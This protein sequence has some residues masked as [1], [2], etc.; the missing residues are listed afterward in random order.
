VLDE[1]LQ[2]RRV[3][4]CVGS[5]GVGKTTVSAA[6]GL[7]AAQLG[8]KTLVLTIDPARRLANSLGLT[9]LGNVETRIGVDQ[10]AKAGIEPKAELWA[11]TLDLR[12]TWD[13]LVTRHAPTPEKRAM[14]LNNRIYRQLSTKLAG[15]LEYMATEK[16]YELDR[17]GGY[18]LVVLDTPPT[19]HALDFI[20]APHR[21]LDV[22]ENDAARLL[23]N[24]ALA[25]GRVGLTIMHLGSSFILRSLAR[26]TGAGLLQDLSDF[27][28][29]FQ[30]MY[31][32]FK[33]R[34]AATRELLSSNRAGFILVSGP[35]PQTI[36]E[37]LFFASELARNNI[38]VAAS[39]VNRVQA[40]PAIAGDAQDAVALAVAL[41]RARVPNEGHPHLSERLAV[42][43]AELSNLARRDAA[44]IRRLREATAGRFALWQ[45]PKLERDVHDLGGL[46]QVTQAFAPVPKAGG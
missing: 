23:L 45:V 24:P 40:D 8:R 36:D 28:V 39:V 9:T 29:A 3:I 26:F 17:A 2:S 42:T 34:A 35:Q 37:A 22:F 15:S 14:I 5:G 7:R 16:V 1:L 27:L 12:R 33:E 20:D 6:L 10:F 41:A 31:D 18:D 13:D 4:V 32:G 11:M 38:A 44:Q 21:L 30:G 19:A 46:W 43:I 25:A